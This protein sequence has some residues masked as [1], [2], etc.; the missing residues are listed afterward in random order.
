MENG[1][2]RKGFFESN[3]RDYQ[4][5]NSVNTCIQNTLST[6]TDEDF[7][8]LNNGVTVLSTKI[9]PITSRELVLANPEIVNGLQTSTEIFNYF[10][11]NPDLLRDEN[12]NILI[13]IITPK[14][15]ESRDNIIFATNNQT[16]IPKASLR[17]TDSIHLQIEIYFK[18][19]GLYY[20]RR[21]NYYKNQK[22]KS[23]E[24]IGVSFLAQCLITLLLR[25]PDFARARPS[26]LLD[27][28]KTYNEL[29]GE[30]HQLE[31]YYN[32][33]KIGKIIQI[34]IKNSSNMSTA[35]KSDI[36]FYL[37]YAVIAK[38]LN[39]K[40]ITF[41]DLTDFDLNLLK[42]EIIDFYKDMVY[43]KYKELG[44]NGRVAKSSDFINVIDEMLEL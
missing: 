35:E 13:R 24:I 15:E 21:K 26:T 4:G 28:D 33:A 44:G 23:T 36:L 8:W 5:K 18:R 10:S 40:A 27:D 7:W 41:Q 25:K 22:K 29:Y 1:I 20:D 19:R 32:A 38:I 42:D 34:N 12:R 16:N 31:A 30:N 9:T 14:S 3:V 11:E 39:K 17:V 43:K 2:L 6:K 37:I